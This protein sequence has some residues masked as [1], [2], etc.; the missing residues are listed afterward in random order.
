MVNM[1]LLHTFFTYPGLTAT[2]LKRIK[3]VLWTYV[4]T[5][6]TAYKLRCN[7][8]ATARP[9]FRGVPRSGGVCLKDVPRSGGYVQLKQSILT[10]RN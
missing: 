5:R 10:D 1:S 9:L 3:E 4:L 2:P 8:M 6:H 7:R